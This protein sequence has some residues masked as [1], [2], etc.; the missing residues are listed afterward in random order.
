MFTLIGFGLI[1]AAIAMFA[2]ATVQFRR[3]TPP[4]WTRSD[5]LAN[6][7]VL[8]LVSG[9]A[10][11]SAFL[12]QGVAVGGTVGWAE[13]AGLIVVPG[14]ATVFVRRVRRPAARPDLTPISGGSGGGRP[15]RPIGAGS[16]HRR[17]A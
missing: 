4:R 7:I 13:L 16:D 3:A 9:L 12:I 6:L 8:G 17:A 5:F 2:W 10:F 1:A 14:M 15:Q 11:G